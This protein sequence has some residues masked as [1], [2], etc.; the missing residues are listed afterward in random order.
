MSFLSSGVVGL[1]SGFWSGV[2]GF[3]VVPD[4]PEELPDP[5]ELEPPPEKLPPPPPPTPL[6]LRLERVVD[7]DD[8]FGIEES[9]L[10]SYLSVY[11]SG[12]IAPA[13]VSML[14]VPST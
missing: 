11:P 5:P 7:D 13:P 8:F 6:L 10:S 2:D 14:P 9:Q 12:V 1:L 3:V 4:P